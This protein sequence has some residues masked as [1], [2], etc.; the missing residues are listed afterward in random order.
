M[1]SFDLEK[2]AIIG[3][4]EAIAWHTVAIDISLASKDSPDWGTGSLVKIKGK[5]F[6]VTCK[7]V[8]KPGY[9]NEDL[10]F[11]YRSERAFQWV[12]KEVIKKISIHIVYKDV[13]KTFPQ[14]IPIINRVYSDDEDD[15]VLL[16]VDTSSYEVSHYNFFDMNLDVLIP[17]ANTPIYFM[18]FSRELARRATVYGDIG[19]FPFFGIS[20]IIDKRVDSDDF[21]PKRHFLIDFR[22]FDIDELN[23]DPYGLSGCGVWSRAPSGPHKLWAANIYLVGVQHGYFRRSE[24]LKATRVE[25]LIQL[26]A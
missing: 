20:P 1:N 11:V 25:R 18:G 13:Y 3:V 7:H 16:E 22:T 6:I 9:R 24:V 4:Q 23:I 2:Q 17:E 26:V 15:L 21:N 10:R 5:S 14:K 19:V 8:V 12:D